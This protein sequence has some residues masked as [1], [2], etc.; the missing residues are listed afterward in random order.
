MA[1]K[2]INLNGTNY[3]LD[4]GMKDSLKEALMFL[5]E[6]CGWKNS[7]VGLQGYNLL[8]SA[9]ND[10]ALLSITA[11][12][13]QTDNDVY[14]NTPLND[15]KRFI[16]VVARYEDGTNVE[17][18]AYSISGTL[19]AGTNTLTIS[20]GGK[21]AEVQI[22]VRNGYEIAL[23]FANPNKKQT[24]TNVAYNAD[25]GSLRVYNTVAYAYSSA[26]Y[27]IDTSA[28]GYTYK[29][30]ADVNISSG[31]P[32][33]LAFRNPSND[34]IYDSS[35]STTENGHLEKEIVLSELSANPQTANVAFFSTWGTD[36]AGD[37]TY[38]NIKVARYLAEEE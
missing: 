36:I 16:T 13:N 1:I 30:S 10:V 2:N 11:T 6:N 23:D 38:S 4:V 35:V 26:M 25:T 9:L 19:T 17:T 7:A 32:A 18:V 34:Q 33:R 5:A 20:Y 21:T 29:V 37:V 24:N 14:L 12:V 27:T 22:A 15:L 31:G 8:N 3:P 28:T